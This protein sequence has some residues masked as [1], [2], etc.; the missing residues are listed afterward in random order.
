LAAVSGGADSV[1]LL[2]A[3][4][5]QL[6][7][8]RLVA[9]HLNHNLRGPESDADAAWVT[10]L[11]AR[12]GLSLV[13]ESRP[14]ASLSASWGVGCEE[15]ARRARYEFLEQAAGQA[16]CAVIALAHTASDQAE[17]VLHHLLR[18]TGLAGLRGIP[19]QRP[20]GTATLVRP[21]LEV[22]RGEIAAYLATLGQDHRTDRS[23]Q[24]RAATRNR[25]RLDLLPQLR[26]EYN[27][28]IDR[29]LTRLARQVAEVQAAVV[30]M[31]G[32]LLATSREST[33]SAA[34]VLAWQKLASAP[35]HVLRELFVLIWQQQAWPR[36]AMGFD[37]WNRLAELVHRGGQLDLPGGVVARRVGRTLVVER[38]GG[39]AP[40]G[41]P[42][43]GGG[44]GSEYLPAGGSTR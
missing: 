43:H 26:A 34:C 35:Q 18:G 6:P 22:T 37:H 14:V 11:C 41:S 10:E 36:Q 31:A 33:H 1:A 19:E 17:T 27:P 40:P 13:A 3:L 25:L 42:P 7:A 16:G 2:A 12:W 29:A 9:A 8:E 28:Q 23:N 32:Q 24:E 5:E 4:R 20:L 15:G 21:L 39:A 38:P 30:H 44:E